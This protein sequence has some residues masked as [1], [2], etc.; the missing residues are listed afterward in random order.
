[1]PFLN[2]DILAFPFIRENFNMYQIYA[3]SSS[4]SLLMAVFNMKRSTNTKKDRPSAQK[5]P[6]GVGSGE[7]LYEP[8]TPAK[9][10]VQSTN[11]TTNIIFS[12]IY[13]QDSQRVVNNGFTIFSI[14]RKIHRKNQG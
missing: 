1:M 2:F 7:G 6:Q 11:R 4:E 12:R 13:I 3:C 5:L 8:L 10:K 9:C 14:G